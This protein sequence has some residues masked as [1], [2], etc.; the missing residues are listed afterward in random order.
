MK[1]YKISRNTKRITPI[2][3]CAILIWTSI[4]SCQGNT[5]KEN[6]TTESKLEESESDEVLPIE[7]F[8]Q[9]VS[10]DTESEDVESVDLISTV[11]PK[12]IIIETEAETETEID[13]IVEDNQNQENN[14]KE[15]QIELDTTPVPTTNITSDLETTERV[16]DVE[17][18]TEQ[19]ETENQIYNVYKGGYQVHVPAE[20][21]WEIRKL[22]D[23]YGFDERVIFGLILEESTFNA[24]AKNGACLGLAQINSYWINGATIPRLTE[25]WKSRKLLDPYDNLITLIEMWMFAREEYHL[26]TDNEHDMTKLL[27]WYNTGD[28][29]RGVTKWSYAKRIYGYAAE[30]VEICVK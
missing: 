5:N 4:V 18:T 24:S 6:N 22:A 23:Q 25:D 29:P 8:R 3:I 2:V 20:L 15:T 11:V 1:N 9:F 21:Q 26:N 7:T 10:D 30:L 17:L 12:E 19:N 28:D 16:L 13:K 14:I 27:Y